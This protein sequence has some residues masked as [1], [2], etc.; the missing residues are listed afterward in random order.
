LG[1]SKKRQLSESALTI[2][3]VFVG[4]KLLQDRGLI[5]TASGL[6]QGFNNLISGAKG[7]EGGLQTGQ[8]TNPGGGSGDTVGPGINNPNDEPPT[9]PTSGPTVAPQGFF[10]FSPAIA[11]QTGFTGFD[12]FTSPSS[13]SSQFI[14][15]RDA[16]RKTATAQGFNLTKNAPIIGGVQRQL[17]PITTIITPLSQLSSKI[18]AGIEQSQ[19]RRLGLR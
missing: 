5:P 2:A 3:A 4:F 9:A 12:F 15:R 6:G 10:N 16:A 13:S 19:L 17:S 8:P 11:A 18:R 7:S 1:K 14:Q